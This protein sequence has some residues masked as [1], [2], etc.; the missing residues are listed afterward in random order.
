MKFSVYHLTVP[1]SMQ[2]QSRVPMVDDI[3]FGFD[4][5]SRLHAI[6]EMWSKPDTLYVKVADVETDDLEDVF[7]ATNHI[8]RPWTEN[9]EVTALFSV[10]A[11]STSVGDVIVDATG[12]K[13]FVDSCGFKEF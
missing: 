13:F 7:R 2:V 3:M 1:R 9:K 4:P 6:I 10:R 12:N 11:R 5:L 8:D